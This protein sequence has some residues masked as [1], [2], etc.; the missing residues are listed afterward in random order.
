MIKLEDN[1]S[2]C[3]CNSCVQRCPEQCIRM[4]EDLEGFLY[5]VIELNVCINCGLC[6]KVCPVINRKDKRSPLYVYAAKNANEEIRRQSSSGGVFTLLATNILLKKGIVFGARFADDWS[7][8]HDYTET[9]EGL[10]P[11]RGSKYVQ[12]LIG[13]TYIQAEQFL[14]AGRQVLY[15]GT[16]CQIA[17]LK[18]FLK[19]QY[20]N[21]LTVDCVCHGVPSPKIW[22]LYLEELTAGKKIK[23]ITFRDKSTGWKNYSF[24]IEYTT[25]VYKELGISNLFM[26]GFLKDLYLRPSCYACPC[27]GLSSGSD[28]TIGDYW[29]IQNILP[30]FDD[31]KGIS[32]IFINTKLWEFII[33]QSS[34]NYCFTS[35]SDALKG[36]QS[37]EKM[38]SFNSY[39]K[40][41]FYKLDKKTI[42]KLLSFYTKISIIQYIRIYYHAVIR[43]IFFSY[44]F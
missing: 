16:P 43:K 44:L 28:I 17:G 42:S 18:S 12:S 5:P 9:I 34:L 35:Y 10:A 14:K 25:S 21:L 39:K 4:Q 7:V 8:I 31:D 32:L 38:A 40:E 3:G 33:E 23:N 11:F 36:N 24:K 22:K 26:K 15:S 27:K 37:I 19:K 1:K 2:C 13:N 30:E 6:E 29:G 41:F 20:D